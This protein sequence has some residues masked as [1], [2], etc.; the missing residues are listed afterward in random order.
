M[1]EIETRL[2]SL[3]DVGEIEKCSKEYESVKKQLDAKID[4]WIELTA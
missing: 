3:T 1:K 4:E 2:S